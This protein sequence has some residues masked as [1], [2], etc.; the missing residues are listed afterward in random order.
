MVLP[1]QVAKPRAGQ[2]TEALAG[3]LSAVIGAEG[4]DVGQN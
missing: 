1:G 4:K 3:K 2:L